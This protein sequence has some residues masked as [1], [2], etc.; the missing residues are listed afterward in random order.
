MMTY[1]SE[2]VQD[3]TTYYPIFMS[4]IWIIGSWLSSFHF[5]HEKFNEP[6][7]NEKVT[8]LMSIFN[9]ENNIVETLSSFTQLTYANCDVVI[10]DDK[11][12]DNSVNLVKNW[13]NKHESTPVRLIELSKNLGKA[14]ALN[15]AIKQI[16]SPY[17]LVTDADAILAHD[18]IENLLKQMTDETVAAVTG[19]PV[20]RNRTTLLAKLQTLEY[21][22][23]IDR[24]KRAQDFLYGGIMTVAGVVVLYRR[25]ALMSVAGFDSTAITED[26]DITWRLRKKNWRI[27]Y[28]PHALVYIL[29][30]ETIHGYIKQRVRWSVGGIEV[31]LKNL[32]WT[33][34]GTNKRQKL[35]LVDVC[36]SHIWSWTVIITSIQYLVVTIDTQ[37]FSLPGVVIMIYILLFFSMMLQGILQDHGQSQLGVPELFVIPFYS[38]FYWITVLI[39][40]IM[41]QLNVAFFHKQRGSWSSPDRGR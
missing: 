2:L 22:G 20:V 39:T 28:T 32:K 38:T 11:S 33:F 30:P 16:N 19:K 35:L 1:I 23:I 36:L 12:T 18:V 13:L 29:A 4:L 8:I 31:L 25:E 9:E 15:Q 14:A 6:N 3:F 24:I 26:I 27:R 17:I 7:T 10:V 41:S 37:T 40:A 5:N 21:V 34:K